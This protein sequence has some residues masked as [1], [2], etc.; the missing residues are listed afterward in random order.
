MHK[1]S[2]RPARWA[3]RALTNREKSERRKQ[4]KKLMEEEY[5]REE[6]GEEMTKV[7]IGL[8]VSRKRWKWRRKTKE[9]VEELKRKKR[10]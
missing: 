5:V 7:K 8:K 4:G 6:V 10:K 3:G 2:L 9:G 1:R